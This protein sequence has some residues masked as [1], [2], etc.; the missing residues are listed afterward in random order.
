[1]VIMV[2]EIRDYDTASIAIKAALTGHLVLSTLHTNDAPSSINRLVDMGVEPFL[3]G[4]SLLLVVAQRLA[5][6]ICTKCTQPY[7]PSAD[8]MRQL[9]IDP[10]KAGELTFYEGQGCANCT[11]T[12]YRGRLALYEVMEMTEPLSNGCIEK[13]SNNELK[14]IARREGMRTLR[15]SGIVKVLEGLTTVSEVLSVTYEN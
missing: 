2:G 15:D 4:A 1:D 14:A 11:D 12:G 13:A 3:V 8:L 6:R 10:E 5:R 7:H 9:G